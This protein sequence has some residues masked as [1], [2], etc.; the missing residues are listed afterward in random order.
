M[1]RKNLKMKNLVN[2]LNKE[3]L[4]NGENWQI[5]SVKHDQVVSVKT[6]DFVEMIVDLAFNKKLQEQI[7]EAQISMD[8]EEAFLQDNM[9]EDAWYAPSFSKEDRIKEFMAIYRNFKAE[10]LKELEDDE[11]VPF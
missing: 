6:N 10:I 3:M 4:A 8:A 5:T 2:E 9:E 1:A 7:Q 11:D